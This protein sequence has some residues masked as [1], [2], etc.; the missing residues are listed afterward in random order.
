MST[1]KTTNLQN[2][3]AASPAFVLASDGSATAN[4]SSLNGGP[5]AGSRNRIIN[6]AME[7]DQRNAGASVTPTTDAYTVDRW[8]FQ[9]S[10]SSKLSFQ[11]NAGSVTPPAGFS[12]YLGATS[13]SAY[14]ITSSDI[15]VIGQSIEGFNTVDLAWGTASAKAI[16]VSFWVR[17]SLTGTFGGALQNGAGNRAY[18]FT[19]S[20]SLA[21]TW[22]QKTVNVTGDTTGTWPTD[23]SKAMAILFGLGNGSTQSATAGTWAA[24][25]YWSATGAT[26]V[27]GTN[28]ATFYITGVQLEPGT[29]ATPFERRSFGAELALCQRYFETF[30]S[31]GVTFGNFPGS[32][33]Y[34]DPA[35]SI[36][37]N[38][39]PFTVKKRA[40]PTITSTAANTFYADA[41]GRV[42]TAIGFD[43][44][45]TSQ[46][47]VVLTVSSAFPAGYTTT[48]LAS[49]GATVAALNASAEL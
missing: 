25:S 5:I 16:T 45:T 10:Q 22:E 2:A 7:I 42:G 36:S 20:I 48:I 15:F 18:P 46:F 32:I 35:S 8:R 28:G 4:L 38:V 34:N 49:N 1:L 29:V 11:L 41:G 31:E 21:N 30:N 6:G 23:N 33:G 17:S 13:L 27:V 14:S 26:S 47:R 24:G 40:L 44:Q 9:T 19:Y 39:I 37:Y 12:S 43:H 3:S